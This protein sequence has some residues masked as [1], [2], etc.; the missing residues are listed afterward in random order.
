MTNSGTKNAGMSTSGNRAVGPVTLIVFLVMFGAS[1]ATREYVF[2][3][4]S[5]LITAIH[6]RRCDKCLVDTER[7]N[8]A[9]PQHDHRRYAP[10]L[11]WI[12][13]DRFHDNLPN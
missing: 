11:D 12:M 7:K 5:P 3:L 8:Q 10:W 9:E 4:Q 2:S 1:P 6:P 13:C